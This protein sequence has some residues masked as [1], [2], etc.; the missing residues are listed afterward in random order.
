[1]QRTFGGVFSEEEKVGIKNLEF[2]PFRNLMPVA[3]KEVM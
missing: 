1:M 3:I 2:G